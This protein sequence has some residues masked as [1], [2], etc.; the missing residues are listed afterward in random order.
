MESFELSQAIQGGLS[1]LT[2][3]LNNIAANLP[4]QHD[5]E[6][7]ELMHLSDKITHDKQLTQ[8][9]SKCRMIRKI[10]D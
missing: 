6:K 5:W 7:P 4:C 8:R 3:A 10:G 9:C 1:Y 2:Q